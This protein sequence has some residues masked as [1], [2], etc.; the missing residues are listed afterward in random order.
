MSGRNHNPAIL[1]EA[2]FGR[3]GSQ[4]RF[5]VSTPKNLFTEGRSYCSTRVLES[6]VLVVLCSRSRDV[7][8]EHIFVTFLTEGLLVRWDKNTRHAQ[9][10]TDS[11]LI[12]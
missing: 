2:K 1:S 10:R 3:T 5:A 12:S 7:F 11:P 6:D 4:F 9:A 8:T